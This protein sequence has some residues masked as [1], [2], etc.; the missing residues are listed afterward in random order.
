MSYRILHESAAGECCAN[1]LGRLKATREFN[2]EAQGVRHDMTNVLLCPRGHSC[3][4][5]FCSTDCVRRALEVSDR[6][7]Y[8]WHSFVCENDLT[9][10]YQYARQSNESFLIA[11]KVLA[12]L[13]AA[14]MAGYPALQLKSSFLEQFQLSHS[15]PEVAARSFFESRVNYPEFVERIKESEDQI[16]DVWELL[17]THFSNFSELGRCGRELVQ[18]LNLHMYTDILACT[19]RFVCAFSTAKVLRKRKRSVDAKTKYA[20]HQQTQSY[21]PGTIISC[22]PYETG[23]YSQ[24]K[25][26]KMEYSGL[27]LSSTLGK[28]EHSC[29]PNVQIE[30]SLSLCAA[31]CEYVALRDIGIQER[32]TMAHVPLVS[33]ISHR[34]QLILKRNGKICRCWRCSWER[35]EFQ[36]VS[37][38]QMKLLAYQAQE[39]GRNSDAEVLLY[40]ALT[41]RP[42]DPDT[43]HSYGVTLLNQGKWGQAH[44]IWRRAFQLNRT[45]HWLSKQAVKDQ[46]YAA[47]SDESLFFASFRTIAVDEIYLT[48]SGPL[49]AVCPSW[50][51]AAES[52]ARSRGGWDTARHKAVPTTDLPIHEI[53]GVMEQWNRLFS[54]VISPFIRDRFRLPTSFGTLYVHDAFVVKY[55]AN[56]GQRELPVHTDQGQFSLTLALHDTQDYSGGGTIFPEHECI[57]RPRCGDFVAFRSSL[58]H[59]GVPITAGVRYIVVA[60]LYYA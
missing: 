47:R 24:H 29:I 18:L 7:V 50:V 45:H 32:K 34:E 33:S 58:T 43:L 41:L 49:A 13:A 27:L 17:S 26:T 60:F 31:P 22:S 44:D 15:W 9:E 16:R 35:E 39:E 6:S 40:C 28:F 57:V 36:Q 59:G 1:C 5:V 14:N 55:N 21:F 53:P 12:R 52:V 46:L 10:F 11:A 23:L 38:E 4:E 42:Q 37:C 2:T 54:V 3:R 30:V 20:G 19:Q 56:E 8:G 48:T 51:E 25:P